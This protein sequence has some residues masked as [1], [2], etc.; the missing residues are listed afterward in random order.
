VGS[1]DG[2]AMIQNLAAVL[3]LLLFIATVAALVNEKGNAEVARSLTELT[4]ELCGA[5]Y[6]D[7][8][9]PDLRPQPPCSKRGGHENGPT[10]DW[11]RDYHS[12]GSL[13][14]RAES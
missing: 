13:K 2:G 7:P 10:T 12:N 14:W 6:T 9:R 11:K 5:V 4:E 3:A 1:A 8:D